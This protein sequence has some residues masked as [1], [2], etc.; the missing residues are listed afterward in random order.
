MIRRLR[1]EPSLSQRHFVP[2]RQF[3]K[4]KFELVIKN[5]INL[6]TK[7]EIIYKYPY[8]ENRKFHIA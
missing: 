1:Q 8:A 7:P 5:E 2:F 4:F 3:D 6:V